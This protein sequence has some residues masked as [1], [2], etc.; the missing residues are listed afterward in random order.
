MQKVLTPE[1]M[2][3]VAFILP[4]EEDLRTQRKPKGEE[5]KYKVEPSGGDL[6]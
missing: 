5:M 4:V 3:R 2:K 6:E 1:E